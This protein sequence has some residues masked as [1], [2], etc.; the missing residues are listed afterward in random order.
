MKK[1]MMPIKELILKISK[2][3]YIKIFNILRNKQNHQLKFL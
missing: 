3:Q 1:L 2:Q